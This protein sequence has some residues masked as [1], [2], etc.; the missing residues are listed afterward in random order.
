[1]VMESESKRPIYRDEY[2]VVPYFQT[3]ELVL[4]RG[5]YKKHEETIR[6]RS[7]EINCTTLNLRSHC[8]AFFAT[9]ALLEILK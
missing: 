1:M 3:P 7:N 8:W 2:T 4:V 5:R 9:L 6:Y